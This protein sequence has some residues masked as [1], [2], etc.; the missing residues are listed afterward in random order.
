MTWATLCWQWRC[1]LGGGTEEEQKILFR[2]HW[3][4]KE[5]QSVAVL[6]VALCC[7]IV[8][9]LLLPRA[10]P[11]TPP[12][13]LQAFVKARGDGIAFDLC[14]A[15]F[16]FKDGCWGDTAQVKVNGILQPKCELLPPRSFLPHR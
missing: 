9:P 16:S 1:I 2:R 7:E 12:T 6:P 11:L 13:F 15:E 4:L 3:S 14:K 5:V 8:I 10:R